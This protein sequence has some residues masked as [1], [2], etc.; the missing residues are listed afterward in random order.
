MSHGGTSVARHVIVGASAGLLWGILMR[1]WMRFI[2]TDPEFSWSGTLFIVAAS[3][4]VGSLLGLARRRRAVGG[5]GWWRSSVLSLLLLGAGG[6]V[7][8]PSVIAGAVA[9]GRPRP[10]WLRV[11]LAVVAVAVQAVVLRS[12]FADNRMMSGLDEVVAVGWYLPLI[13]IEAW[14]FAVVFAPSLE[15]APTPAR[16][17][18]FVMA[19]PLI[20]VSAL[21]AVMV[22]LPG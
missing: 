7:M 19:L 4:I 16:I 3:V 22:G 18:R 13:T 20:G 8:W 14:A 12:V 17:K 15:S 1:L 11:G 2:S 10:R 5:A 9:F 21:A 6:A